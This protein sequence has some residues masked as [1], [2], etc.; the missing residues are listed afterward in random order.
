MENME[1]AIPPWWNDNQGKAGGGLAPG[2]LLD[3][4]PQIKAGSGLRFLVAPVDVATIAG[5]PQTVREGADWGKSVSLPGAP[6]VC[7]PSGTAPSPQDYASRGALAGHIFWNP[8]DPDGNSEL[9]GPLYLAQDLAQFRRGGPLDAQV[10]YK[11]S[12]AYGNYGFGVYNA[13][14]GIPL[15]ETLDLANAYGRLRSVYHD[16]HMDPK[17]EFIPVENVQNISKGYSDYKN[18][19]LCRKP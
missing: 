10:R 9:A 8:A 6:E 12:T 13:A 4:L 5:L 16:R 18:G 7:S 19:T 2:G 14:A 11:G 17:Y 1:T 3:G 15:R